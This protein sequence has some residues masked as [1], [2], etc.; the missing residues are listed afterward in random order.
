MQICMEPIGYVENN[1]NSPID[2]GWS[3]VESNIVFREDLLPALSGL[4]E[5]SHVVI[6]FYMHQAQFPTVLSRSPQNRSDLPEIGILSQ[7]SKHRPNPIGITSVPL[8]EM[9]GCRML[10]SGL[11]AINGTPILDIKPYY[12]EYDCYPEAQIPKWVDL[13]MKDYF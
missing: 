9:N 1:I 10:V 6:I 4:N 7:R 11:D 3:K 5:F 13:L 8:M 2:Q 12:P